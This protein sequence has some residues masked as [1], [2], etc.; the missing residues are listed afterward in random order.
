LH[1]KRKDLSSLALE[2]RE[3]ERRKAEN[4]RWSFCYFAYPEPVNQTDPEYQSFYL[5]FFLQLKTT[6]FLKAFDLRR[7]CFSVISLNGI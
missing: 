7:R 6:S 5:F 2:V 4:K 3:E 1:R